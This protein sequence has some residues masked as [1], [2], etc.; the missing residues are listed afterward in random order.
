MNTESTGVSGIK[1]LPA[2]T[3]AVLALATALGMA[4]SGKSAV[5]NSMSRRNAAE[6]SEVRGTMMETE[7]GRRFFGYDSGIDVRRDGSRETVDVN[8]TVGSGRDIWTSL[9]RITRAELPL[10]RGVATIKQI[11]MEVG[12][13]WAE[14]MRDGFSTYRAGSGTIAY[15]FSD[16]RMKA[17]VSSD[18]P[19]TSGTINGGYQVRCWVE[20]SELG[21]VS[22]LGTPSAGTREF[23]LDKDF[24]T[25]FCS[26]LA[27]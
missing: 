12:I 10:G 27:P 23:A 11:P 15:E 16:G 13:G 26:S 18:A 1:K 22:N 3:S 14:R 20:P 24:E 9:F 2:T 6:P 21:L 25:E 8:V 7:D 4:C 5:E 17:Q 19:I